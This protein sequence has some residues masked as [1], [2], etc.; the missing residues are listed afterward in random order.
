MND[1]PEDRAVPIEPETPDISRRYLPFHVLWPLLVGTLIGVGLRLVFSADPGEPYA[2]MMGSFILFAPLAV[3]AV[4]VYVAERR[5]RRTVGYYFFAPLFA[6][7]LFV[8]GTLAINIEGWIC[9]IV[10]VPLFALIGALGGLM[11]GAICRM[12]DWPKQATYC[13]AVLPIMLGAVESYIPTPDR[14]G[15]LQRT[16][17][18]D[19][20]PADVWQQILH[21]DHIRA[22]EVDRGWMYRIGVPLP[23]A[24]VIENTPEGRVRRITMGKGIHFDQVV[25]DWRPERY[26]HF[27]YRFAADSF[28]PRALDDHVRIGG[29]YFDLIDTSYALAPQGKSTALTIHM[30]YRVTT[31]FNWYAKPLAQWLIG[32]FEE[33]ILQFYRHRSEAAANQRS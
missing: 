28:P 17:V 15:E 8:L 4:T 33:T 30:S 25:T 24:G 13:L 10:I 1:E 26:V 29:M 3:G 14:F 16:V 21:A 23:Q 9:A 32:D 27:N 12:T 5:K 20:P 2:T 7:V 18:I 31:S 22:E 19:A 6:N 11:M